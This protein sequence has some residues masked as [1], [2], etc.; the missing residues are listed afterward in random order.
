MDRLLVP[1]PRP[2]S[3]SQALWTG[4]RILYGGYFIFAVILIA[5]KFG[6]QQPPVD[7]PKAQAFFDGLNASGFV[8]PLLSTFHVLGG[9]SLFL[10]RTAPLGVVLLAPAVAGIFFTHLLLTGD[11]PVGV[12]CAAIWVL[13]A[14]RYRDAFTPLWSYRD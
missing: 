3:V 1:S 7:Q 14:L 11:W 12:V 6:G 8:N 9:L 4:L 10:N 13:L 5:V 2:F